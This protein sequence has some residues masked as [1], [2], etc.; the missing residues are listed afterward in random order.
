MDRDLTLPAQGVEHH[1]IHGRA[2]CLRIRAVPG[3]DIPL[4]DNF[5]LAHKRKAVQRRNE[6]GLLDKLPLEAS[7]GVSPESVAETAVTGVEQIAI[8]TLAYSVRALD[9]AMETQ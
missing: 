3:V 1:F 6:F 7:D 8:G 9:I 4:R 2:G 5:S